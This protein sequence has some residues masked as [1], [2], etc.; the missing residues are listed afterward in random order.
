M[1]KTQKGKDEAPGQNKE[2]TIIVNGTPEEW[3]G[4]SISFEEVTDLAFENPPYGDKTQFQV[5]YSEALGHKEGRL[6]AGQEVKIKE[7]TEFDV[8]PTGKS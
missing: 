5:I 8:T 4:R 6:T 3:T 2:I 7:N 1:E